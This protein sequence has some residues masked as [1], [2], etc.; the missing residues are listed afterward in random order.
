MAIT[1]RCPECEHVV[2]A[3]DQ[4]AGLHGHCPHCAAPY[5]IPETSVPLTQGI[6][7]AR[8]GHRHR[9]EEQVASHLLPPLDLE[10]PV[11]HH[12]PEPVNPYELRALPGDSAFRSLS[13]EGASSWPTVRT[14][15]TLIRSGLLTIFWSVVGGVAVSICAGAWLAPWGMRDPVGATALFGLL[16]VA[17]MGLVIGALLGFIGLCLCCTAPAESHVKGLAIGSVVCSVCAIV[18]G[19]INFLLM[20]AADPWQRGLFLAG[21]DLQLGVALL[22]GGLTLLTHVV[23]VDLFILFLKGLSRFFDN[24][25]LARKAN[26]FLVLY[27]LF[28]GVAVVFNLMPIMVFRE[29]HGPPREGVEGMLFCL[30]LLTLFFFVVVFLSLV[31]LVTRTR[32]TLAASV[33]EPF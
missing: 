20:V 5:V 21:P 14:G 22:L 28:V 18:L 12:E 19:V 10:L 3:N 33:R 9:T 23:A 15:L 11:R 30:G 26:G 13:H 27:A 25:S 31:D 2:H 24:P 17:L 1:F 8:G 7:E 29:I 4:L 6:T 32:N 16:I